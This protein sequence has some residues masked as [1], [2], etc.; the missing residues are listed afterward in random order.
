MEDAI[1]K[2]ILIFYLGMIATGSKPVRS[3]E[4]LNYSKVL[5]KILKYRTAKRYF[6]ERQIQADLG[7]IPAFCIA[8]FAY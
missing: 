2:T 4:W 3:I 8:K 7:S 5:Y 6:A 1:R